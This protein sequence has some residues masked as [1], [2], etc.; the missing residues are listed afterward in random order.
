MFLEKELA[1]MN[2]FIGISTIY[3]L[4]NQTIIISKIFDDF[5]WATVLIL[6]DSSMLK[7][8]NKHLSSNCRVGF[9]LPF[10]VLYIAKY[11]CLFSA[12][13]FFIFAFNCSIFLLYCSILPTNFGSLNASKGLLNFLPKQICSCKICGWMNWIIVV[14]FKY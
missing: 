3:P 7:F 6:K 2:F 4:R 10:P 1:N 8:F 11:W 14:Q 12:V 5:W 13:S 9:D